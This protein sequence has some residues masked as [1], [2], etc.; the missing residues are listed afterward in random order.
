MVFDQ[1]TFVYEICQ[2]STWR[3]CF[4]F[5]F[6]NANSYMQECQTFKFHI[7][8]PLKHL[9]TLHLPCVLEPDITPLCTSRLRHHGDTDKGQ[10]T[11]ISQDHILH[12]RTTKKILS[13]MFHICFVTNNIFQFS[14]LLC[15]KLGSD[16]HKAPLWVYYDLSNPF[17]LLR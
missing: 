11:F 16:C 6:G 5:Y 12:Q 8:A 3:R 2:K 17:Q 10:E 15:L 13:G 14:Y 4:H 7:Q 9:A 1:T